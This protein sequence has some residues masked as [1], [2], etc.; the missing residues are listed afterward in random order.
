M[1]ADWTSVSQVV[2]MT[3]HASHFHKKSFLTPGLLI[4]CSSEGTTN[5]PK[6]YF[7]WVW[8]STQMNTLL[9]CWLSVL[10][11]VL[12]FA[13]P[14][15]EGKRQIAKHKIPRRI[16]HQQWQ[17]LKL[18]RDSVAIFVQ[19]FTLFN[20]S[21]FASN[22]FSLLSF[23]LFIS[24]SCLPSRCFFSSLFLS[25]LRKLLLSF[26]PFLCFLHAL[27]L[28][29]FL[30]FFFSPIFPSSPSVLPFLILCPL[31]LPFPSD[32]PPSPLTALSCCCINVVKWLQMR[33]LNGE[34][35]AGSNSR[36]SDIYAHNR[37]S[38][39]LAGS[40]PDWL[41]RRLERF[42]PGSLCAPLIRWRIGKKAKQKTLCACGCKCKREGS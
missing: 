26:L 41:A 30:L 13:V 20:P 42:A 4:L 40:V 17:K 12:V 33:L 7:T 3:D 29:S 22:L 14:V 1:S 36:T 9:F 24:I 10:E 34:M 2:K 37:A 31:S 16:W 5:R 15:Q 18:I 21:L 23:P 38:V 6:R 27:I 25:S 11:A 39:L 35:R 19:H 32:L 8:L 28:A